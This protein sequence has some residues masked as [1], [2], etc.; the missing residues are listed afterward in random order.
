MSLSKAL[1][2]RRIVFGLGR[3]APKC[4]YGADR[5]T[6]PSERYGQ[7]RFVNSLPD[8]AVSP[9]GSCMSGGHQRQNGKGTLGAL[10]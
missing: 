1:I 3:G 8:L 6:D 7:P 9:R 5:R 2:R 10:I 4:R